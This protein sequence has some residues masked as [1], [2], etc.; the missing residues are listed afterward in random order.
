MKSVFV[1]F[2]LAANNQRSCWLCN[3]CWFQNEC[4]YSSFVSVGIIFSSNWLWNINRYNSFRGKSWNSF[5]L[6]HI[7]QMSQCMEWYR[8]ALES[9]RSLHD[10]YKQNHVPSLQHVF[11]LIEFWCSQIFDLLLQKSQHWRLSRQNVN[12][13]FTRMSSKSEWRFELYGNFEC[14]WFTNCFSVF[15]Y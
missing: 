13:N 3:E 15:F 5:V 2:V 1:V 6:V 11:L 8:W 10:F 7:V 12:F 4:N 14:S 9:F